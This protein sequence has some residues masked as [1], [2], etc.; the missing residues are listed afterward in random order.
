MNWRFCKNNR[1]PS[2][3]RTTAIALMLTMTAAAQ[4]QVI[5]GTVVDETGEPVIGASVRVNGTNTGVQTD[6]DGKFTLNANKGQ[7]LSISYV[8]MQATTVKVDGGP[9]SIT[10]K[11]AGIMD[12][13]MV[14]GYGIQKK[15]VVTAAIAKVGSEDLEK[16]A[17]VRI[18][19]ALK[20]LAA[21]VTVTSTSGA[22]GAGSQVRIR[23]NGTIT[24]SNPLYIVDG[25]PIEGTIDYLSPSDIESIEVLK[26][27]A[28][29]AVYGA[30]AA[31]GV[32]LVTTKSGKQGK[33]AV[34]Y[35][36]SYGWQSKWHKR[37]VLNASEYAV[38]MNEGY[39]NSGLA[40]KYTDPYNMPIDTDWQKAVFNDGAPVMTHEVNV[41]GATDKVNYYL[42]MNYFTQDGIVGGNYDKSNYNRL[43]LRS[44]TKYTVFDA[45]K[46]RKYLQKLT[47]TSNL[48]Y[49]KIKWV[50]DGVGENGWSNGLLNSALTLAP[51]LPIT[52]SGADI[53]AKKAE[54]SSLTNYV[55]QYDANGNLFMIPGADYD[56]QMNPVQFLNTPSMGQWNWKHKFVANFAADL[57]LGYGFKFRT[58]YGV[59]LIFDGY[60]GST[61]KFYLTSSNNWGGK[62]AAVV[63]NNRGKVWQLEN[64]LTW[65]KTYGKHTINVVLGQSA[66]KSS[67]YYVKAS[68]NYLVDPNKPYIDYATGHEEGDV[69]AEGA[70]YDV[71]TLASMFA[72]ASYNYDE[73]YMAQVTVRRDGSS[74]FG[75]NYHYGTFPSFSAGWNITNEKFKFLESTRSWLDRAKLR[76]SWGKN[77][78][79]NIG[80]YKYASFTGNAGAASY[81]FGKGEGIKNIGTRVDSPANPNLHWEESVQT[82]LGL[83]L[84]FLNNALTFSIDYYIKKTNGMLMLMPTPSY[85]SLALPTANVGKMKNEGV[86]LELGYKCN[87]KGVKLNVKGNAAYL[88]NTL[89]NLGNETGTQDLDKFISLGTITRGENG[90]PWPY[91]YG[92]KTNGL[93]QNMQEVYSYTN[94][95]GE[96][97]QPKA[98]PG[99]IRFVDRNGDGVITDEDKT[100]IGKGMPDWTFGLNIGAEWK[101]FDFN[102]FWQGTAGNDI[103]DATMRVDKQNQNLPSWMLGRWTGEGT[104]N[105]VPRY[106]IGASDNTRSSDLYVYDG[107]YFRLKNIQ[108]GYTLPQSLIN[109][110]KISN[111]RVYLMA[112]NL[113]TFTKYHGYDPEVA[114]G[115]EGGKSLGVDY[116]VY[117]QARTITIGANLSF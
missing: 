27:A 9:M 17:P 68:K 108:L 58:S 96:M 47:L 107:S 101:G 70:P 28:S 79:E 57:E 60:E 100:M 73:R 35:N 98:K 34:N 8:G 14:V 75:S 6:I 33:T 55:P 39:L 62:T 44:N 40:P 7:T 69:G 21:G 84:G 94:A 110:V 99:D 31:N 85:V 71:A 112:E 10:L 114:S 81:F 64:V 80:N 86:E 2:R 56:N 5:K 24:D 15:S 12:E 46:E 16:T 22:P 53:A 106:T 50:G 93:F 48:S 51:T 104:S 32:I 116:G 19:N 92:F 37:S 91:F 29:G 59:D 11:D 111:L 25:M 63:R 102:M 36:F 72:R 95:K 18:D 1:F 103:F 83:D 23:G 43:S 74:R 13:V 20:G 41:S 4:Q 89:V 105:R 76:V 3:V 66:K 54:Y 61:D 77:G 67:G 109:K 45:S 115:G 90:L 42:S 49:S 82:D 88:K 30:R 87:I 52:Y 65:D 113:L 26:D 117:P 38:L 97:I 78:N